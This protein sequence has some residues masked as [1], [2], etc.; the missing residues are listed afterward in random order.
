M[1]DEATK[2]PG[3]TWNALLLCEE[4]AYCL[5]STLWHSGKDEIMGTLKKNINGW[6]G[7]QG[8]GKENVYGHGSS[9]CVFTVMD[10]C[11]WALVHICGCVLPG[12]K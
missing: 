11:N 9:F 5:I 8:Q 4:A 7:L 1:T 10:G 2:R 12:L 6:P 3:G